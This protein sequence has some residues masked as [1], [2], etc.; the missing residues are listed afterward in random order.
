MDYPIHSDTV[1]MEYS[2]LYF[3]RL[4][5]KISIKFILSFKIVFIL[6]NSVDTD[7]ILP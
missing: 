2:I 3:K 7:E 5:V 6:A 4:L 1:S